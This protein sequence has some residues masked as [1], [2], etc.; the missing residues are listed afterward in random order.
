MPVVVFETSVRFWQ[1]AL[2]DPHP[3]YPRIPI[4]G[5]NYGAK[6]VLDT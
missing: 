3:P 5:V 6:Q 1:I 2:E 4:L